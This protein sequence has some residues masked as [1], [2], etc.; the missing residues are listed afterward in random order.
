MGQMMGDVTDG[1]SVY[2]VMIYS[3]DTYG[4]GHLRRSLAI[5]DALVKRFSNIHVLIISGSSVAHAFT[6]KD[7]VTFVTLPPVTKFK[8]GGYGSVDISVTFDDVIALRQS[9]IIQAA[10]DFSPDLFLVDKEPCGLHGEVLPALEIVQKSGATIVLGLRDVLDEPRALEDEWK[11]KGAFDAIETFYEEIWVYGCEDFYDPLQDLPF[12]DETRRKVRFLGFLRREA[13]VASLN[14]TYETVTDNSVLVMAGGGGDGEAL[15]HATMNAIEHSPSDL[16][17]NLNYIFVLGPFIPGD[18]EDAL[19]S[20]AE[21][22]ERIFLRRFDTQIEALYAKAELVIAMGGYNTFCEIMSFDKK[23][24]ILPRI[25]PRLEQWIRADRARELDLLACL[26]PKSA[27]NPGYMNTAIAT[28]MDRPTPS[29]SHTV[30]DFG[31]LER[32]CDVIA[33]FMVRQPLSRVIAV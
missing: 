7:R 13:P 26:D 21:S 33:F 6:A 27:Q 19:H 9:L 32:L 29:Q 18:S 15:M 30:P 12:A 11:Q 8:D 23:A 10:K 1:Q 28:A 3:H 17:L 20:R 16:P 2:R 25:E 22:H 14:T 31:G 5:A 4:L 24:L